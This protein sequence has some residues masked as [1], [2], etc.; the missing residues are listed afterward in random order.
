MLLE[1]FFCHSSCRNKIYK[2]NKSILMS[3]FGFK[4]KAEEVVLLS[5]IEMNK[6]Y[7]CFKRIF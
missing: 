4:I 3:V 1:L 7:N 6:E 2:K 5:L